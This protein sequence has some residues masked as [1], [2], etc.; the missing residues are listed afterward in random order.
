MELKNN[1]P[2]VSVIIPTY[3]RDWCVGKSIR[4]VFEQ[5]YRPIEC[6]LVDD[7][8]TDKTKDIAENLIS[9]APDGVTVRYI[10]QENAGPNSARNSGLIESTGELICYLDSDDMLPGKSI[11]LRVGLLMKNTDADFC[12]GRTAV[13]DAG[14]RHLRT[15]N[16]PWPGKGEARI[17]KYLFATS[18]PLIRRSICFAAGPWKEDDLHG[19]EY[20]Y[21]ARLK[22][23]CNNAVFTYKTVNLYIKHNRD[24]IFDSSLEFN[25]AIYRVLCSVQGL[26]LFSSKDSIEERQALAIEFTRLGD[27]LSKQKDFNLALISWMNAIWLAPSLKR[28]IRVLYGC[29]YLLLTGARNIAI[30]HL[31]R[32]LFIK[33]RGRTHQPKMTIEQAKSI[34]QPQE[35]VTESGAA[36]A[37]AWWTGGY[38]NWGDI[39]T[40]HLIGAL[41]GHE[42]KRGHGPGCIYSIGSIISNVRSGGHI[43]GCGLLSKRHIPT[44]FPDDITIHAV[45]G[46]LTRKALLAAGVSVPEVYG[47]PVLLMPYLYREKKHPKTEIGI[48][49]HYNDVPYLGDIRGTQSYRIIDI[50]SGFRSVLDEVFDCEAIISSSLHGLILAEAYGKPAAWLQIDK[51][52]HL[53]GRDFKFKDY[54][55]STKRR[56]VCNC[57]RRSTIIELSRVKWLRPPVLD[58]QPLLSAFPAVSGLTLSELQPKNLDEL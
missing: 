10:W 57:I 8:S 45:R 23:H 6:I 34:L 40:P 38:N 41:T 30:T 58:L 1:R 25:H 54:I 4:S 22:F 17:A 15:M 9:I 52:K 21:F 48:I 33:K 36:T 29:L 53:A 31:N 11:E 50:Q 49:C 55:L 14:G 28:L 51:G 12:Y 18:A 7:G 37:L 44:P 19:Q 32:A 24:H 5:T 42:V 39:V 2:L 47:D 56:P 16:D 20:E 46:P 26:I 27:K 35:I 43:W 3:N 13:L